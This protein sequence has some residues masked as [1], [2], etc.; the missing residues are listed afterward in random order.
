MIKFRVWSY[1]RRRPFSLVILCAL[2]CPSPSQAHQSQPGPVGQHPLD[3]LTAAEIDAAA[4]ILCAAPGFPAGALFA[5]IVLKEPGKRDVLAYTTDSND[6]P[7]GIRRDPRSQGQP[8]DRGGRGPEDIARRVLAISPRGPAGG[9]RGRVR[10]ARARREGRSP[11]AGGDAQTWH[12][13]ARRGADRLLGGGRSRTAISDAAPPS[14]RVVLQR[15]C[16]PTST[17]DRLRAW[18]CSSI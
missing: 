15:R 7:P 10:I 18:A 11:L 6:G 2:A 3:P 13:R 5:T 4:G 12:R 1:R 14:G 9:A 8:H 17:A 16:P